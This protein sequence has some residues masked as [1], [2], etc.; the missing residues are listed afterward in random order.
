LDAYVEGVNHGLAALPSRPWEYWILQQ[1]P[2]AWHADDTLL[3]VYSMWWDLQYGERARQELRLAVN[4]RLRGAPDPDGW[5]PAM[6]FLFPARTRWDAPIDATEEAAAAVGIPG[7]NEIDLRAVTA[8]V[9]AASRA[10]RV[11][12]S[13]AFPGSNN[14][15]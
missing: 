15:A 14:W 8:T 10:S 6:R 9:G 7:T 5:K 12:A 3:V 2:V 4:A 13:Q 1:R 11:Q